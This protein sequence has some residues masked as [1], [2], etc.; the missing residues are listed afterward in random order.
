KD[1]KKYGTEDDFLLKILKAFERI[2]W[3]RIEN[4]E[5]FEFQIKLSKEKYGEDIDFLLEYLS[6]YSKISKRNEIYYLEL[7]K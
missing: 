1:I 5:Y 7:E 3:I 6:K 2:H 4:E